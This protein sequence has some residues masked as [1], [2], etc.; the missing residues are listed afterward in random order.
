MEPVAQLEEYR[1]KIDAIDDQ[2][3]RLML[4]R[5][6]VVKQ[7]AALKGEHWPSDCH[8]RSGREGRMH[9]RIAQRFKGTSFAVA[10]ALTI[11]RQMIGASTHVESPLSIASLESA[12][13][14]A[15][16]ARE[17]FGAQSPQSHFADIGS[18]LDAL[19]GGSCNLLL[20][21]HDLPTEGWQAIHARAPQLQ[22]FASL[23][24]A[25]QFLPAGQ[26]PAFSLAVITPEPSDDDITLLLTPQGVQMRDGFA[27][28]AEHPIL[29]VYPRP[30]TI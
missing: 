6:E 5:T 26:H 21:P 1:A 14:H 29:G 19:L 7:V 28:A 20:V 10:A 27:D 23:P 4:E 3:I 13:H 9:R 25:E 12:P 2:L 8:I 17:Y 15:S 22:V 16:L 11:W 18:A 24:V 30:L